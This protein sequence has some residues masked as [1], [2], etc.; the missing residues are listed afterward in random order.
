D[1]AYGASLPEGQVYQGPRRLRFD[2][3][4]LSKYG[5]PVFR[6]RVRAGLE[7]SVSVEEFPTPLQATCGPG[8]RRQLTL[9]VAAGLTPWLLAGECGGEPR[10]V[11]NDGKPVSINW[12]SGTVQLIAKERLVVLPQDGDRA[13]VLKVSD[14]TDKWT[15]HIRRLDGTWQ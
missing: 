1:P 12:K 4:K 9:D 2:G 6:Y 14:A 3:Y 5:K 11:G 10:V 7:D 8:I 13:V 15:W